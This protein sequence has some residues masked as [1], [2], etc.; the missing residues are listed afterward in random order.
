MSNLCGKTN[1]ET[2]HSHFLPPNDCMDQC[3]VN[4]CH[5]LIKSTQSLCST[6]HTDW[7][8]CLVKRQICI[9]WGYFWHFIVTIMN[10]RPNCFIE[11]VENYKKNYIIRHMNRSMILKSDIYHQTSHWLQHL[12][13]DETESVWPVLIEAPTQSASTHI[14][15]YIFDHFSVS[16]RRRRRVGENGIFFSKQVP[17]WENLKTPPQSFCVGIQNC[18][19]VVKQ[20]CH[21]VPPRRSNL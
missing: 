18:W 10:K 12:L 21:A 15:A 1:Q 9:V 6:D 19:S 2:H 14:Q 16:S 20:W 4:F 17:E 11:P 13:K 7:T 8:F 3:E 5:L